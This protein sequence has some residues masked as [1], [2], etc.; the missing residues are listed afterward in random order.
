MFVSFSPCRKSGIVCI[1]KKGSPEYKLYINAMKANGI[2]YEILSAQELNCR[3]PGQ[4]SVPSSCECVFEKDGGV[5]KATKAVRILQV[6]CS[7]GVFASIFVCT[8]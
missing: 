1:G 7:A 2:P 6:C 3:Y 4:F 5:L 8:Y